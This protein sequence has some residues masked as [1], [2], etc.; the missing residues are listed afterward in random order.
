M[1]CRYCKS[2]L[3]EETIKCPN[4]S[5]FQ[6]WRHYVYNINVALAVLVALITIL[7]AKP[8]VELLEEKRAE[9]KVS[10]LD[11]SFSEIQF[12]LAN[13][14]NRPAAIVQVELQTKK[15]SA[16]LSSTYYLS[17]KLKEKLL[18]PGKAVVITGE[19]GEA[20]PGFI[21]HELR[22]GAWNNRDCELVI[23]YVQLN[24]VKE[25]YHYPFSCHLLDKH[26]K[27]LNSDA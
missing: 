10:I 19:N 9:I 22:I 13:I 25:Y 8:V 12:L 7:S 4:C 21:P 24:G 14:G 1:K 2:T 11:G 20:I 18:A 3:A 6:G 15:E 17:N 23:V 26:N 5:T 27:L 16:A